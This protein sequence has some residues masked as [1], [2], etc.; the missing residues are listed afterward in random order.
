MRR[1]VGVNGVVSQMALLAHNGSCVKESVLV[2]ALCA[3]FG[4]QEPEAH[5]AIGYAVDEDVVV[6]LPDGCLVVRKKDH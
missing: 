1:A 4:V 2:C 3:R 6:R 5:R